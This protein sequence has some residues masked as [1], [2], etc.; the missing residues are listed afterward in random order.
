MKKLVSMGLILSLSLGAFAQVFDR[1]SNNMLVQ[2]RRDGGVVKFIKGDNSNIKAGTATISDPV[3]SDQGRNG[4]TVTF[5]ITPSSD[6]TSVGIYMAETGE[7]EYYQAYA[8]TT[9][10]ALNS[11]GA[12]FNYLDTSLTSYYASYGMDTSLFHSYSGSGAMS[13]THPYLFGADSSNVLAIMLVTS[14]D[15]TLVTKPF[16]TPA[17]TTAGGTALV[18]ISSSDVTTDSVKVSMIGND[19]VY[20]Y[21]YSVGT[22]EDFTDEDNDFVIDNAEAYYEYVATMIQAGYSAYF[23]MLSYFGYFTINT[24]YSDFENASLSG[25]SANTD[26]VIC[27]LPWNANG[28]IGTPS[29]YTF[30][31]LNSGLVD[32]SSVSINVYPNPT[33]NEINISTLANIDDVELVNTLGQIVYKSEVNTNST[34]INVKN[35]ERGTYFVKVR[36]NG[37]VSTSKIIVK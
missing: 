37:K 20:G 1:E 24:S 3:F 19:N 14:T 7:M 2:Q 34:N 16:I 26:Y 9:T 25:L 13:F 15:S 5:T 30:S 27:T 17:S 8:D 35:F 10:S 32:V 18:T 4:I 36:T 22:L 31:T 11:I 12:I 6:V 29:Y 21:Y 33:T 23:G 28:Q